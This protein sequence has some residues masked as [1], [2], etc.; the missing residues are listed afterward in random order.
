MKAQNKIIVSLKRE[1][2]DRNKKTLAM[3]IKEAM[4]AN[5]IK[6]DS[7]TR[8]AQTRQNSPKRGQMMDQ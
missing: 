4:V 7:P 6:V 8:V 3:S 1:L 2:Q 5:K